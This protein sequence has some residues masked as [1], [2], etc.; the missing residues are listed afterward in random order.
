MYQKYLSHVITDQRTVLITLNNSIDPGIYTIN[1]SWLAFRGLPSNELLEKSISVG[2]LTLKSGRIKY[3]IEQNRTWRLQGIW[4]GEKFDLVS[5][6]MHSMKLLFDKLVIRQ[7]LS[8]K[9]RSRWSVVLRSVA[10]RTLKGK[11]LLL[12]EQIF[13]FKSWP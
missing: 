2:L 13:S 5:T 11:N 6:K 3:R 8:T 1:F 12:Q 9:C 10:H 4:A 7:K